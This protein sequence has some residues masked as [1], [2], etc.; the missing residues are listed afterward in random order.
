LAVLAVVVA[1]HLSLAPRVA[2]LDAFYHVGHAAH[3]LETSIL[4]V[5]FPWG[6]QS[7]IAE[8]GADLWWGFHVFLVPFAALGDPATAIRFAGFALTLL[9]AGTVHSVLRRH[10]LGNEGWWTAAF[11]V[12]VPNVLYRFVMV[13]PHVLSL[14]LAL[15]LLS[16][17]V[18]GRWWQALLAAAAITWLHLGL[19]WMAP[20]LVVAYAMAR[21]AGG[22]CGAERADRPA[23]RPVPVP[24]AIGVVLAGTALGWLLRPNPGGAA[25][26]AG[27]QIV[28]LF[29]EKSTDQ[30]ILFAGE[31]TPLPLAEWLRT[32]WLF[33]AAWV[34]A[35][36]ALVAARRRLDPERATLA[37]TALLASGA[38]L[39]LALVSAR[40][41]QVEWVVFGFL[42]LPLAWKT[43]VPA[44]RRRTVASVGVALLALHLPWAG[45]RHH[46]NATRV[47]F[48]PDLM[49]GASA[50]LAANASPGDT[51]FHAKWDDFGPLF[52][53]N[54]QVAYLSGMDPIF[55]YARDEARWWEFFFLS[56][57]LTTD[58]TCDAFPCSEGTATP[59][60]EAIRSHFG[61]RWVVVEPRRNPE[62]SDYL[63]QAPGFELGVDTGREMVFRVLDPV[64]GP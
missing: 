56:A 40:R 41:A 37:I 52:A 47:A 39:L 15:V 32:S 36:A 57:E 27:I 10:G 54:R 21:G 2:A 3:Y 45:W 29:A 31:L 4:D 5:A 64:G 49:R 30:P 58:Y 19:F 22:W 59:T 11:L 25:A 48:P 9:L 61:A 17:L 44:A 43:S 23:F 13:R 24:T 46:L 14:A 33:I 42:L 6:T 7:A 51:V 1:A 12:A 26:L 35:G 60:H 28:Q 34:A 50:W 38:F 62:L 63:R 8:H 55:F 16:V 18:R 53:R 20:G